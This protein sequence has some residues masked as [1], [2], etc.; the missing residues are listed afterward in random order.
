RARTKEGTK[1]SGHGRY[2]FRGALLKH[3]GPA[4]T[5][6]YGYRCR[7]SYR[8]RGVRPSSSRSEPNAEGV[9]TASVSPG[10]RSARS[11][12]PAK[13]S[14]CP[15]QGQSAREEAEEVRPALRADDEA[16]DAAHA[17]AASAIPPRKNAP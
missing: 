4:A 12:L 5:R 8:A 13:G 11:L 2:H 10:P 15:G 9:G 1:A 7:G 17:S 3:A 16:F 14:T 6:R